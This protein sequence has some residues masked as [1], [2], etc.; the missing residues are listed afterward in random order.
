M[1]EAP[2][3]KGS[4]YHAPSFSQTEN[5]KE[6][7]ERNGSYPGGHVAVPQGDLGALRWKGG[8]T[9][10]TTSGEKG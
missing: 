6:R 8:I 7:P 3:T 9:K 2:A 10:K 4:S 1:R 5:E